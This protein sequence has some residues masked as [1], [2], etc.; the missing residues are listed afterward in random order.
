MQLEKKVGQR[1][2]ERKKENLICGPVPVP[3]SSYTLYTI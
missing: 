2:K 3:Q 1:K